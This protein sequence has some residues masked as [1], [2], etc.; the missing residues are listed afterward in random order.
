MKPKPFD[1]AEAAQRGYR[2]ADWDAIDS[3][4]L[5]ESEVAALK[6]VAEAMPDF[7]AALLRSVAAPATDTT[8]V[9]LELDADVVARLKAAGPD[10]QAKANEALR[11]WLDAAA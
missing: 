5:D 2:R 7:H 8:T 4:E 6:P 10:W 1:P 11:R 3:P 9:S